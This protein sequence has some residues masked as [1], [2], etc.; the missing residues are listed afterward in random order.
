LIDDLMIRIDMD[1]P[2]PL[3]FSDVIDEIRGIAALARSL[4]GRSPDLADA[5]S[6]AESLLVSLQ[7]QFLRDVVLG[8]PCPWP[9]TRRSPL[10]HQADTAPR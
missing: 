9:V 4:G 10:V 5:C 7:A 6:R 1:D 2:G 8:R 3:R